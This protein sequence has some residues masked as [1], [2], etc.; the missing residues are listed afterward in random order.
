MTTLRSVFGTDNCDKAH[1]S[2][3]WAELEGFNTSLLNGFTNSF[4]RNVML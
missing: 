1:S 3:A 4:P 2:E